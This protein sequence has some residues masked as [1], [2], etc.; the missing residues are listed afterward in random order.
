MKK[1]TF[2][3][4]VLFTLFFLV[5]TEVFLAQS[6]LT[7]ISLEQQIEKSSLVVEGKVISK[8]SYWDS[9]RESI[10]TA[11]T[12]EVY[13]V[14]KGDKNITV[15]IITPGGSVGLNAQIVTPSLDLEVG[16]LGV[17]TLYNNNIPL[18]KINKTTTKKFK[19]YGSVQGFYKYNIV[20]DVAVNSFNSKKGITKSFYNEIMKYTKSKYIETS[21]FDLAANQAK[22]E[23][24]KNSFLVPDA[25]TF[26]PNTSFAG[27]AS[28][29]TI[30]GSNF[31]GTKGQ[32]FFSNAD[33]GGATFT[34]ALETQILTWSD[35]EI[36]VE[37]P[38]KA[39]TGKI[40]VVDSAAGQKLSDTDLTISYAQ[41]TPITDPDD[42]TG[43]TPPGPNGPLGFYAFPVRHVDR[44]GSGGYIWKM[45]TH[46][47]TISG[48]EASFVRAM[49]T[50]RCETNINWTI[51]AGSAGSGEAE[52]HR[53]VD[54][55]VNIIAFDD[56]TSLEPLDDLPDGVAGRC[57]SYYR[58]CGGGGT[59]FDW[60]VE[61]LDI[62]FDDEVNWEYGTDNATGS[63]FDF[64]SVALHELGH[65]HQLGHVI[66]PTG[67]VMH[68]SINNAEN[69]RT[70]TMD[71][72]DGANDVQARSESAVRACF[73]TFFGV[74]AMSVYNG[75]CSL[76]L[77]DTDLA[78]LISI[79]PNPSTTEISIANKSLINLD[80]VVIYD[81]NGREILEND[82][83]DTSRIKNIDI[84]SLSRGVYI[85]N[86]HSDNTL[87]SKKLILK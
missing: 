26:S 55:N 54:D 81:L 17:F 44:D 61:E 52:Q 30:S 31:G 58:A 82:L 63:M 24:A 16:D 67:A 43:D 14:F 56:S 85:I 9:K 76:S 36:T 72:I 4:S 2:I 50:W 71:D 8:K 51:D 6:M 73:G 48:A 65:G 45:S 78:N 69:I 62:V 42:E 18:S 5:G 53:A 3:S 37:I 7:E 60:F 57:T 21:N 77:E 70:L 66:E 79:Y 47:K 23:Q 80:K 75:S 33:D 10:Y 64:E 22:A 40:L 39:G 12:V 49:D 32:V 29:L 68:Y 83:S 34:A 41:L 86:I 1:I 87:I 74:S 15:E 59:D 28:V 27:T 38:S 46:F 35:N 11:N 84:Q 25:F 13:K 20:T 19:A